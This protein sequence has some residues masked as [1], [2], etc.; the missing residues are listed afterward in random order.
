[1]GRKLVP[2]AACE[3]VTSAVRHEQHAPGLRRCGP[4]DRNFRDGWPGNGD[5][6]WLTVERREDSTSIVWGEV[7]RRGGCHAPRLLDS[8]QVAVRRPWWYFCSW[9]TCLRRFD[10]IKCRC[11]DSAA[12]ILDARG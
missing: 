6:K 9:A 10:A 2:N 7:L 11:H 1:M 5:W 12:G 8:C 4:A 3:W